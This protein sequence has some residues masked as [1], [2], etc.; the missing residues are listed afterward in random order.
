MEGQLEIDLQIAKELAQKVGVDLKSAAFTAYL[1]P[2][3]ILDM[4]VAFADNQRLGVFKRD[5]NGRNVTLTRKKD[6]YGRNVIRVFPQTAD[7][8]TVARN[9][10]AALATAV[11]IRLRT[12]RVDVSA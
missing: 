6:G 11:D 9:A 10:V 7:P 2:R 5:N 3:Q 4:D 12:P 1:G 8:L